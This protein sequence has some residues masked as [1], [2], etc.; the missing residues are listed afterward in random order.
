LIHTP[1]SWVW[2][3]RAT[4]AKG[5]YVALFN[6]SDSPLNLKYSWQ[7]LGLGAG[8]HVARDLWLHT[9]LGRTS[10]VNVTLAPHASVLYRVE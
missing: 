5:K 9:T 6:V 4:K 10:G 3:A 1:Q 8:D 7:K 2:T